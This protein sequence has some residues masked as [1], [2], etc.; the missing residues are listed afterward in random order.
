LALNAAA[1]QFIDGSH[2]PTYLRLAASPQLLQ[3]SDAQPH[4]EFMQ[5]LQVQQIQDRCILTSSAA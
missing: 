1:A 5:L 2:A 3:V 4:W